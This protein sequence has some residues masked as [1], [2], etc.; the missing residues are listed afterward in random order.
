LREEKLAADKKVEA[1]VAS[2]RRGGGASITANRSLRQNL[3]AVNIPDVNVRADG[4]VVR[5][6]V[7]ADKLFPSGTAQ[8]TPGA[9][10]LIDRV[11]AEVARAYPEQLVGVEGHTDNRAVQAAGWTSRHQLSLAQAVVVFNRLTATGRLKTEQLVVAG[12][13][14]NHPIFSNAHPDGQARNRRIE[15]V[16]YPDRVGD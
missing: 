6:D 9:A 10:D 3:P 11:A 5:I 1:M 16:V 15:L 4:E 7:P 12:H 2:T 14:A 13:G 8:L